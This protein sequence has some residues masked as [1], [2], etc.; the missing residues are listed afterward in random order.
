VSDQTA[1][2]LATFFLVCFWIVVSA[3]GMTAPP[4]RVK[5]PSWAWLIS[6]AGSCLV[7]G[8][9]LWSLLW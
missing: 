2:Y 5:G 1:I 6:F 8:Y 3:D 7:A 9:S 4:R